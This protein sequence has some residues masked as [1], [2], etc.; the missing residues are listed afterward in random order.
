MIYLRNTLGIDISDLNSVE[1]NYRRQGSVRNYLEYFRRFPRK[2]QKRQFLFGYQSIGGTEVEDIRDQTNFK[3]Y[4]INNLFVDN[5]GYYCSS[6]RC[7]PCIAT[8]IF[9][10]EPYLEVDPDEKF[11]NIFRRADEAS[12]RAGYRVI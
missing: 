7:N 4:N 2:Y 3:K 1:L 8:G 9:Y 11:E 10:E 5:D 6:D 12:K